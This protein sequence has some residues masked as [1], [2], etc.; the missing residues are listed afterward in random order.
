MNFYVR[1]LSQQQY[2]NQLLD[3]PSL[4]KNQT[5][6][7][8]DICQSRWSDY[9][10]DRV[11]YSKDGLTVYATNTGLQKCRSNTCY[12]KKKENK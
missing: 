1:E 6:K 8:G 7:P 2:H 10:I 3:P 4:P 9:H 12:R 5:P 11:T